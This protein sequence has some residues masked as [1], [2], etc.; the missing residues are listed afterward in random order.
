MKLY[1]VRHGESV[2]NSKGL[3][4]GS[5][6]DPSNQ[7][8][9]TGIIQ[10]FSLAN[11]I[12]HALIFNTYVSPLDRCV[13]TAVIITGGVEIQKFNI[14]NRLVDYC[15]SKS[16]EGK[17]YEEYIHTPKYLAWKKNYKTTPTK[18]YYSDGESYDEFTKRLDSF[19][20]MLKEKNEDALIVTHRDVI[21]YF[22]KTKEDIPNCGLFT[23]E[24]ESKFLSQD[25]LQHI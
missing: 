20:Y 17:Y 23:L 14:D 2:F 25:D 5:G 21:R 24:V 15:R 18:K 11:S 16:H 4:P 6:Q 19:M 22:L 12:S 13:S 3:Y 8:N 10:A 1:F 9:L 7:L